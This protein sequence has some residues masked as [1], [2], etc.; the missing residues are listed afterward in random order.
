MSN[1]DSRGG[2]P[3]TGMDKFYADSF[4]IVIIMSICCGLIGLIVNVLALVQCK[5]E[6]AKGNAKIGLI[7]SIV[8]TLVG[9]GANVFMQMQK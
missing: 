1:G 9:I 4:A 7:I 6:K 5:N 8:M 3:L 2:E